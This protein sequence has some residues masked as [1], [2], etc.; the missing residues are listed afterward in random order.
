MRLMIFSSMFTVLF[1][2]SA[3]CGSN[4]AIPTVDDE[5]AITDLFK[6]VLK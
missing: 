2:L 4:S 5:A 3:A 1:L 6:K